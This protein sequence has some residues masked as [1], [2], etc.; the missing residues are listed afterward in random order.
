M[1]T[2][3]QAH[4]HIHTHTH[5]HAHTHA[6]HISTN[7]WQPLSSELNFSELRREVVTSSTSA[8]SPT[9]PEKPFDEAVTQL[10]AGEAEAV[11]KVQLQILFEGQTLINS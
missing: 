8:R 3:T 4:T 6:L 7:H 10:D 2:H 11:W 9:S 5:P 1:G